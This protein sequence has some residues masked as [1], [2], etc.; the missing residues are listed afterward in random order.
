MSMVVAIREATVAYRV[1]RRGVGREMRGHFVACKANLRTWVVQ[2]IT[3]S[4][5]RWV[6][7]S[8]H[9][10]DPLWRCTLLRSV[11]EA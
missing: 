8:C 11:E 10:T 4:V 3:G 2:L 1:I 9:T 6:R 7:S 5:L